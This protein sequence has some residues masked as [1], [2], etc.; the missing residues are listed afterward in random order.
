MH[1]QAHRTPFQVRDYE[2]D[3]QGVVNNAVYQNYLEHA[4]HTYLLEQGIDFADLTQRGILLVVTRVELNYRK[5]LS[6]GDTFQVWTR[7]ERLSRLKFGF[8][9]KIVKEPE[10]IEVLHG[11]VTGTALNAQGRPEIPPSIDRL[12]P[13][14]D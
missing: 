14:S 7:V 10:A 2:C 5:S 3:L 4:R 6:S 12:I 9:Q 1:V 8:H 13:F 11:L